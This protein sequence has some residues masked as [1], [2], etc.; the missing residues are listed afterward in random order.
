[1]PPKKSA[2]ARGLGY[3]HRKNRDRLLGALVDGTPCWWCGQPL[4]RDPA[5][6]PDGMPLEADHSIARSRG[7][8]TADRLLHHLCN[9]QRQD[10]SRDHLR[11][12][13][14]GLPLAAAAGHE[15]LLG[16]RAMPWPTPR[17]DHP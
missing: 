14:T 10:G 3:Q 1:M 5:L 17:Q 6:N 15:R 8:I 12:A 4:H 16:H 2:H 11:P 7:G 9:R 13:V